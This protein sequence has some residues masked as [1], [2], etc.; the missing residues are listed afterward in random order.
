MF[1]VEV[2]KSISIRVKKKI[3]I[4]YTHDYDGYY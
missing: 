3:L 1:L 4:L 2:K